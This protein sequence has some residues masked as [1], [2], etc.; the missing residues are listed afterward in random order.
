M[1]KMQPWD[2][3]ARDQARSKAIALIKEQGWQNGDMLGLHSVL[4]LMV[5]FAAH[6]HEITDR[7]GH[8][9]CGCDHDAQCNSASKIEQKERLQVVIAK[10]IA[11]AVDEVRYYD[12]PAF[13]AAAANAITAIEQSGYKLVKFT[14]K[15]LSP[16]V[17][18]EPHP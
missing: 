17:I 11:K 8:P 4:C 2:D 5:D 14:E 1:S 13:K 7:C 9:D 15:E 6:A 10:A 12:A 16:L 3:L 18:E